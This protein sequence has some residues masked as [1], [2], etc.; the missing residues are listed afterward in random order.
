MA[1]ASVSAPI[2]CVALAM[3]CRVSQDRI[4]LC[5]LRPQPGQ[6]T[7]RPR[8]ALRQIRRCPQTHRSLLPRPTSEIQMYLA[9]WL[10][11]LFEQPGSNPDGDGVMFIDGLQLVTRRG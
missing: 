5:A 8:P 4:R 7:F 9:L 2:L 6:A 10:A 11:L 1:T 3:T